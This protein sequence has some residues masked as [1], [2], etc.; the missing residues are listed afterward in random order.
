MPSTCQVE[1]VSRRGSLCDLE[2][3]RQAAEGVDGP[4]PFEFGG[5]EFGIEPR[6]MG[7]Y[8]YSLVHPNAQVGV[9]LSAKLPT[10]RV[11]VRSEFLHAVGPRAALGWCE[12]VAGDAIGDVSWGLGRLDLF[13]DVQG[14]SLDGDDRH[15]FV[16]K[17]RTS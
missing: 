13:C 15:R 2:A 7:R 6:S 17:A 1:G 11:Q 9:T 8:R 16:C 10:L 14:W 5:V 3:G 4:V 12:S